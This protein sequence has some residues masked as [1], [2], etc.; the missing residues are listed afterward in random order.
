MNAFKLADHN[1]LSLK[2]HKSQK[3]VVSFRCTTMKNIF[4]LKTHRDVTSDLVSCL[5]TVSYKLNHVCN[6]NGSMQNW[7][8]MKLYMHASRHSKSDVI[9]THIS[10]AYKTSVKHFS[11]LCY[12]YVK[13]TSYFQGWKQ[14]RNLA[15]Y[16][17]GRKKDFLYLPSQQTE[18]VS[19]CIQCTQGESLLFCLPVHIHDPTFLPSV[20][21]PL[22]Q[23]RKWSRSKPAVALFPG[24]SHHQY[25]IA[26][27]MPIN[28]GEGLGD[29]VMFG[30]IRQT[31]YRW[32]LTEITLVSCQSVPGVVNDDRY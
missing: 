17:T 6:A 21:R 32:Y 9:N 30:C 16:I 5:Q 11:L 29:L 20:Q 19:L 10:G 24:H 18:Q 2:F 25:L 26:C 13:Y 22:L 14:M 23:V 27:S 4:Q 15:I 28:G 1:C 7:Y 12:I 8:L 31:E 3:M